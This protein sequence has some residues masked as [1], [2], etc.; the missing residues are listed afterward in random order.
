MQENHDP[1][2]PSLVRCVHVTRTYAVGP[3]VFNALDDV[4]L[5]IGAGEFVA[6]VGPS[7]SGKSTLLNL[8]AG[9]DKP[10]EGEVWVCGARIDNMDENSLARWRGR[11]IGIVFQFFQLLP[12]LTVLENVILPVHLRHLWSRPSPAR[13][14]ALLEAVG[15][16]EHAHKLPSELSGGEKQRVA[17]ARALMN[18]PPLILAD[19]P[20]GNLDSAT[21]ERIVQLL[22]DQHKQGRSI[23]L[24][25]HEE[26]L[27]ALASRRIHML[28]GRIDG[29][30]L[31]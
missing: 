31:A 14:V 16:V 25:T 15:M 10:T 28:D 12:T 2:A 22:V 27:A 23:I 4:S 21:G 26:R 19:E 24:V 30:P 6:I 5:A 3:R 29:D 18:E 7:G 11:T 1:C 13:A 20:T 9:I 8:M 17:L